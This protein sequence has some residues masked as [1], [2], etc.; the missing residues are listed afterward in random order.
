MLMLSRPRKQSSIHHMAA[1]ANNVDELVRAAE[2]H[3]EQYVRTLRSIQNV[4]GQHRRERADSRTTVAEAMTPPLRALSLATFVSPE[5]RPRAYT[6]ETAAERPSFCPSPRRTARSTISQESDFIPDEELAF[7]PL[8]DPSSS[9]GS[10]PVEEPVPVVADVTSRA[11]KPLLKSSFTDD[12]LMHHLR[13]TAFDGPMVTVLDEVV[14]RRPDIDFAVPFRDFASFERESYVSTTFEVY[15]VATDASAK[16][17][18]L[19]VEVP[20]YIKYNGDGAPY[21]TVDG[22]VD[23]PTVWEAIREVNPDNHAVGRITYVWFPR[24][25]SD[26]C[27]LALAHLLTIGTTINRTAS[28]RNQ[29]R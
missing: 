1:P 2:H 12:A 24:L 3:H 9:G 19:D 16:K 22:I 6:L 18:T 23:A 8:L 11:K 10:R 7:I 4:V 25:G 26:S 21:E 29:H 13:D 28:S 15:E 27:C 20:A 5:S 14:R 17:M